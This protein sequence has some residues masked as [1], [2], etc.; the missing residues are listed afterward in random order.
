MTNSMSLQDLLAKNKKDL[1]QIR[2]KYIPKIGRDKII[3]GYNLYLEKFDY[4][5]GNLFLNYLHSDLKSTDKHY[6]EL[7]KNFSENGFFLEE[8]VRV[9]DKL[10]NKIGTL[11][12]QAYYKTN[13]D[14][15]DNPEGMIFYDVDGEMISSERVLSYTGI[16]IGESLQSDLLIKLGGMKELK[17]LVSLFKKYA[18]IYKLDR[19]G[20]KLKGFDGDYIENVDAV[21]N[22]WDVPLLTITSKRNEYLNLRDFVP[23]F[24]FDV[25]ESLGETSIILS[26]LVGTNNQK[27]RKFL[28]SEKKCFETTKKYASRVFMEDYIDV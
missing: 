2:K 13:L 25:E 21:T 5:D 12:R 20:R 15:W 3:T 10:L 22:S 4:S 28:N 27:V 11:E 23:V 26:T 1:D 17:K 16:L 14:E 6:R 9:Q 18:S 24:Q 8:K 7:I 19:N